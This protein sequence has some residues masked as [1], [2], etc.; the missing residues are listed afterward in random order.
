MRNAMSGALVAVLMLSVGCT[1]GSSGET[2]TSFEIGAGSG[3][4]FEPTWTDHVQCLINFAGNS[5][6][7]TDQYAIWNVGTGGLLDVPYDTPER[8]DLWAIFGTSA[9]AGEVHHVDGYSEFDHYHVAEAYPGTANYDATYDVIT[10]WPGPNYDAATYVTARN[11][12]EVQDQIASGQLVRLTLPE[13]GFP[14]FVLRAPIAC[15]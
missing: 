14:P 5:S 12:Q 4:D 8:A 10:A 3:P 1:V 11:K 15:K 9:S 2:Q 7:Q 13:I 6:A